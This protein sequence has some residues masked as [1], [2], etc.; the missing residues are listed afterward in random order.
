MAEFRKIP[1]L[2]QGQCEEGQKQIPVGTPSLL[3]GLN[4]EPLTV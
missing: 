3:M 1:F 4:S 2:G